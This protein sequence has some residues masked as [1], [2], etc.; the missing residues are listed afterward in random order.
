MST[1][2]ALSKV[3]NCSSRFSLASASFDIT[4]YN[5]L[6]NNTLSADTPKGVL[7][8]MVA[9]LNSGTD[10]Q[11]AVGLSVTFASVPAGRPTAN[12]ITAS[13]PALGLFAGNSEGNAFENA[14]AAASGIV[15][16]YMDFGLYEVYVFESHTQAG[17]SQV[18][19]Y[20]I[21]AIS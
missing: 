8:G 16:I 1:I 7:G 12:K 15:P 10:W 2:N 17:A 13:Y 18:A 3:F 6:T 11:A 19:S 21:E 14:P 4:N 9:T 20:A 5:N